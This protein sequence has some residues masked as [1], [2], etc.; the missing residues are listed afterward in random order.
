[1]KENFW[2]RSKYINESGEKESMIW[3]A[4]LKSIRNYFKYER[5]ECKDIRISVAKK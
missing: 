4:D 1:M 2:W 3:Y 5:P